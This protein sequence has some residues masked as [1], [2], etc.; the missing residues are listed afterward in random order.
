[1]LNS[2]S[3]YL[4]LGCYLTSLG[5]KRMLGDLGI[6]ILCELEVNNS[7]FRLPE[8]VCRRNKDTLIFVNG[9]GT[10]HD[11]QDYAKRLLTFCENAKSPYII[12]NTGLERM[13]G[14]WIKILANA[15]WVQ[16]RTLGDLDN[17]RLAGLTNISYCPDMLFYSGIAAAET[18]PDLPDCV[19]F[20][21]SHS[22]ASNE[23]LL[24]VYRSFLG[25]KQ[26]LNI[27]FRDCRGVTS[28]ERLK[29]LGAQ[30]TARLPVSDRLLTRA[31]NVQAQESLAGS[32]RRWRECS[33]LVTGR[34]HGACLAIAL[35]KPFVY[36][37]SNTRKIE[38]LSDEWKLGAK[39]GSA[40]AGASLI[41]QAK[42]LSSRVD[43]AAIQRR[44]AEH[45]CTLRQELGSRIEEL[46]L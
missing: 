26:W 4:H 17:A 8:A 23:Q 15:A 45:Y 36:A 22:A 18:E 25:P 37:P 12:L 16:L 42:E 21:D 38:N 24:A 46:H 44:L 7:D 32:L 28:A 40:D 3:T 20:S 11:D 9:E 27:H 41:N 5:L 2:T 35:G 31:L 6:D 10:L 29:R 30:A 19:G 13:S 39:I 33:S 34:Y 1:M 14:P 43:R